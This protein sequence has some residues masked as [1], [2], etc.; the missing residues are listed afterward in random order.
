M[1][2]IVQGLKERKLVQWALTYLAGA[3]LV[4]QVVDV[5]GERWGLTP[6]AGR[7]VDVALIAG[8]FVAI[9]LAWYHGEQGRQRVGGRELLILTALL[10]VAAG[11]VRLTSGPDPELAPSIDIGGGPHLAVIP[12]DNISP[13]PADAFYADGLHDEVIAGLSR[14]EGLVV[15]SRESVLRFRGDEV[16]IPEIGRALAVSHVLEAAVRVDGDLIKITPQLIDAS[17]DTHLWTGEYEGDVSAS[18]TLFDVQDSIAQAVA[19]ALRLV[20]GLSSDERPTETDAAYTMYLRSGEITWASSRPDNVRAEAL[21]RQAI[22]F[23]P[24]FAKAHAR[25]ARIYA[26]RV[27]LQGAESEWAD[28]AVAA[29]NQAIAL[30]RREREGWAALGSAR[31]NQGRLEDA[32]YAYRR[33]AEVSPTWETPPDR[34][35]FINLI[36]GRFDESVQEDARALELMPSSLGPLLGLVQVLLNI[37]DLAGAERWVGPVDALAG[38]TPVV[39]ATSANLLAA[40]GRGIEAQARADSLLGSNAGNAFAYEIALRAA[41]GERQF[42]RAIRFGEQG[43]RLNPR[44]RNAVGATIRSGYGY[45]LARA[46]RAGEAGAVLVE[47][48]EEGLALV[49]RGD[50]RPGVLFDVASAYAALGDVDNAIL[51][52]E[53]AYVAGFRMWTFLPWFHVVLEPIRGDRRYQDWL[54]RTSDDIARMATRI[55]VDG[56]ES[57]ILEDYKRN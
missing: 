12:F 8:L 3:W 5:L 17:T 33:A 30:N 57:Q 1:H 43:H 16:G 10:A 37:G 21:L 13:D 44:F 48:I 7:A 35:G 32:V 11:A 40:Q 46:G 49:E 25:L 20:L 53:R 28:S 50:E 56:I 27:Q 22:D 42:E 51:A 54:A 55:S 31:F 9:V 4:W 18:S 6:A 2:P 36:R 45:A 19:G 38:N 15:R 39:V 41:L 26:W 29:A 14:I 52:L 47:A 24:G 34:L 23:D